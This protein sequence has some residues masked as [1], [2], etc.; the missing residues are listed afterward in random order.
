MKYSIE[1]IDQI[2]MQLASLKT[3]EN[4]EGKIEI[5]NVD[6]LNQNIK[7]LNKMTDTFKY[8]FG[9]VHL[10]SNNDG[11]WQDV[12]SPPSETFYQHTFPQFKKDAYKKI[13]ILRNTI[14]L[15]MN[16]IFYELN[17]MTTRGQIDFYDMPPEPTSKEFQYWELQNQGL[18]TRGYRTPE[19]I[20][21]EIGFING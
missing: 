20:P 3:L 6:L 14:E 4:E 9:V 5:Q 12:A 18:M 10:Q 2:E 17:I 19:S 16:K 11:F 8:F 1:L 7:E 15:N 21:Y 13:K